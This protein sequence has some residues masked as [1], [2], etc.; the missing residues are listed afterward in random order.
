VIN[1]TAS[2]GLAG[3]YPDAALIKDLISRGAIKTENPG[4]AEFPLPVSLHRGE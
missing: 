1:E 2:E 3:K 4:P